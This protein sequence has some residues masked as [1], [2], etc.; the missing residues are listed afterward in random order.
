VVRFFFFFFKKKAW[1]KK[2]RED[3]RR[4]WFV[5]CVVV[6]VARN[7]SQWP[8][9]PHWAACCQRA[10]T[11]THTQETC[12]RHFY[13]ISVLKQLGTE[14]QVRLWPERRK[15]LEKDVSVAFFCFPTKKFI[16]IVKDFGVFFLLL[17][18]LAHTAGKNFC[19]IIII[20]RLLLFFPP[21]SLREFTMEKAVCCFVIARARVQWTLS[22]A[23][24]IF[25]PCAMQ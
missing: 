15:P 23:W 5:R 7:S 12:V 1:T 6:M 9:G 8:S 17:L 21:P 3:V 16:K 10:H 11:H 13:L 18:I 20:F 22:F 4:I 14:R 19:F 25:M 24:L 2:K